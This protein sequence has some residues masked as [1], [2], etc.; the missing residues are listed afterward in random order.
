VSRTRDAL[1]LLLGLSILHLV[2]TLQ[3]PVEGPRVLADA[4]RLS[5]DLLVLLAI[6]VCGGA[7]GRPWLFAHLAAL[8]LLVCLLFRLACRAARD[9]GRAFELA[10][11]RRLPDT[12]RLW[13]HGEPGPAAE[14][15]LVVA[16]L[17]LAAAQLL[18]A[19]AFARVARTARDGAAIAWACGL[20][21]V[22]VAGLA[23]TSLH[24]GT[25]TPWQQSSLGGIVAE[26]VC[27]AR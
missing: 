20:Q 14:L 18:L 19:W 4:A 25:R 12:V 3:F 16:V 7:L 26:I 27:A 5:P 8:G 23:C 11:V 9:D 15:E 24:P 10:D 17:A 21:A 6:A 1:A 2:A 13:L 22:V